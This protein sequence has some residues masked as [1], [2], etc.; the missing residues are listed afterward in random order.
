M[1]DIEPQ[2]VEYTGFRDLDDEGVLEQPFWERYNSRLEM[3]I[4]I[5]MAILIP[6]LLAALVIFFSYLLPSSKDN[7]PPA[8]T[9]LDGE[10]D[11]GVG[12]AGDGGVDQ[13]LALG[14]PPQQSDFQRLPKEVDIAQV[15]EEIGSIRVDEST[16]A[17]I[18]DSMAAAIATLNK[19]LR[20]K[21]AGSRKG[22]GNA[23]GSGGNE[24]TGTGIG[25]T[26]SDSTR[27]RALRWVIK[28]D[29]RTG[30]DYLEQIA[31]LGGEVMLQVNND[32]R[33][34][35]LF[36]DPRNA[37]GRV[38]ASDAE[39]QRLNTLLRFEDIRRT[40]VEA[41]SDAL[42][43]G[44]VPPMFL[45][46]FPKKLEQKLDLLERQYQN[47]DPKQIRETVYKV[48]RRGGEYDLYVLNQIL[49]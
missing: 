24:G 17:D 25:G 39:L 1:T 11:T 16:D 20:D 40:S 15:K 34:M 21:I 43:L 13:P 49:K 37:A 10:D 4:S 44:Y 8:M 22:S 5:T 7:T 35:Y 6:V 26:G 31:G 23:A 32:N 36:K 47:K 29:T 33:R 46:Y 30:K 14:Q 19:D 42:N 38:I 2:V 12:S 41:V 28:F 3:P 18:S 27:S 48:V 45:V 9:W